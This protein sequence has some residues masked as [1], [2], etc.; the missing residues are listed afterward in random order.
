MLF[1]AHYHSYIGVWE[2]WDTIVYPKEVRT[3]QGVKSVSDGFW[4][5]ISKKIQITDDSER[6][7]IGDDPED[8]EKDDE[9]CLCAYLKSYQRALLNQ[10]I[11]SSSGISKITN[12]VIEI[13]EQLL[14][15]KFIILATVTERNALHQESY[16]FPHLNSVNN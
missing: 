4:D 10:G 9:R 15:R 2:Q 16:E 13:F 5:Y 12:A 14:R 8:T 1:N 3:D 11:S 6:G 7:K